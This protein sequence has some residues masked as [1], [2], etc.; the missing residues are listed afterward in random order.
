METFSS[1]IEFGAL[2]IGS[3]PEVNGHLHKKKGAN[4]SIES[5]NQW[6]MEVAASIIQRAS[7]EK[8]FIYNND[9]SEDEDV[10]W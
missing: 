1:F 10:G 4:M 6:M 8:D 5:S 9:S 2:Y 7:I 3:R